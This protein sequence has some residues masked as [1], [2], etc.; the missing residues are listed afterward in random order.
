MLGN[1]SI[2][3]SLENLV[4]LKQSQIAVD[5]NITRT[6]LSILDCEEGEDKIEQL[7]TFSGIQCAS[8]NNSLENGHRER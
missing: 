1:D 2:W 8:V 4:K 7:C 6:Y 3:A 5:A